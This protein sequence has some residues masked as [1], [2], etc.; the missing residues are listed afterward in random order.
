MPV[1]QINSNLPLTPPQKQAVLTAATE[2]TANVMGKPLCSVMV[3]LTYADFLMDGTTDPAVFIDFHCLSG[4][5][6]DVSRRLCTGF[7]EIIQQ[8]SALD[9]SRMYVNFVEVEGQYA[10]RFIN[11][12]AVCPESI[13]S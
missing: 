4:L 11:G 13:L 2:L 10:W 9:P 3:M 6:L 12:V 8:T 1:I 5:D 7:L